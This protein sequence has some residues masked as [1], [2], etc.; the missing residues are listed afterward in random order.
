MER[1]WIE[2]DGGDSFRVLDTGSR[3]NESR[4]VGN[5]LTPRDA[6]LW[7]AERMR[8]ER[9]DGRSNSGDGR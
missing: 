5:F 2:A 8:T 6:Q 3:G 7:I 1:Y 9:W 4:V